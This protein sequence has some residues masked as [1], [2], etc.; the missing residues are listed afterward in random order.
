MCII[1]MRLQGSYCAMALSEGA[2]GDDRGPLL[3]QSLLGRMTEEQ[4]IGWV[5]AIAQ[6]L[7]GKGG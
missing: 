4:E 1:A 5:D 6:E 3:V 2:S 7:V